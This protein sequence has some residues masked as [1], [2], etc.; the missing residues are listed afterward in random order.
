MK[1]LLFCY[2]IAKKVPRL[3]SFAS[4]RPAASP[5][6]YCF[7]CSP[8][9]L[10][11]S[12]NPGE[13]FSPILF[14]PCCFRPGHIVVI[15]FRHI[16]YKCVRNPES[17]L[18]LCFHPTLFRPRITIMAFLFFTMPYR[19]KYESYCDISRRRRYVAD[20]RSQTLKWE[21]SRQEKALHNNK[22]STR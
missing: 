4:L 7:C 5:P 13:G 1:R 8:S 19:S 15:A 17:L 10:Q 21:L 14:L 6:P 22:R 20:P 16:I 12:S 2:C 3:R 18:P 11:E 9:L